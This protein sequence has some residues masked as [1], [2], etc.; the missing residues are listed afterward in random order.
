M[1]VYVYVCMCVGVYLCIWITY[2]IID[3]YMYLR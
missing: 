2:N 3:T 1:C